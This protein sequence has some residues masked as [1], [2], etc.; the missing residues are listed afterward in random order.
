[1]KE[2]VYPDY[3]GNGEMFWRDVALHSIL[4]LPCIPYL[5]SHVATAEN[6]CQK[7]ICH[8]CVSS[9]CRNQSRF[10]ANLTFSSFQPTSG[11]IIK[12]FVSIN[13]LF[14]QMALLVD[15]VDLFKTTCLL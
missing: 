6:A 8:L 10:D 11:E 7:C 13:Y 15:G 9:L 5:C 14:A 2:G 4:V 3:D 12:P 1:V